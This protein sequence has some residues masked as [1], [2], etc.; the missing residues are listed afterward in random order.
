VIEALQWQGPVYRTAAISQQ[1]TLQLMQD[2]MR[3][4]EEMRSRAVAPAATI[5]HH[6][7][8]NAAEDRQE[9]EQ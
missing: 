2:L 9:S 3:H 7:P 6:W 8:T 5:Q 1:G 4:L